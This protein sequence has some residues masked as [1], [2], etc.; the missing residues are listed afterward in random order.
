MHD[1]RGILLSLAWT[2]VPVLTL[3]AIVS[4]STTRTLSEGELRLASNK[5]EIVGDDSVN[6]SEIAQY[7]KQAPNKYFFLG[8]NPFL[9]LYNWQ[10]GSDKGLAPAIRKVGQA[11]VV[12]NRS[13]AESS[14]ENIADHLES[15]G[16]Y[17]STVDPEVD[18]KNKLAHVRYVVRPGKRY[19]I[20]SLEFV[21]P[22]NPEFAAEFENDLP[23][24]LVKKG[25]YINETELEAETARGAQYFRQLGYYD[26]SKN[27]YFFEADTLGDRNILSYQIREYTR[28]EPESNASPVRKYRFG[29][30]TIAHSPDISFRK[31]LLRELNIIN[32]G[33]L[34]SESLV[35]NA[36]NRFSSLKLFNGVSIEMSPVDSA[37]TVDCNI[38]LTQS[39]QQGLKA[40]IEA[41]T[42]SSGLLGVSPQLSLYHKNIFHGGEWLTLGFTG[43]FQFMPQ[44]S[45]H[46]TE[47]GATAS[48]SLPRIPGLP[49]SRIKGPNIPRTEFKASYNYQNRPEYTRNMAGISVGF[50][51]QLGGSTFYQI[52]PLQA[53]FIRLYN[54]DEYFEETLEHNPYL[55]DSYKNHLDAGLGGMLYHTTN[56]DI[57]PRTSYNYQRLSFDLSGNAL[58]IFSNVMNLDSDGQAKFLGVPFTQ[59]VRGQIDL[60]QTFRWGPDNGQ[61]LALHI[62]GGI[63]FAYGNSTAMP[64]EKQF[65]VGGASSMRGWQARALGPG[66][67][68]MD[69]SFSIPS[70]TGDVKFEFDLEYRFK[71]FWKL[72]GALFG[73]A[74]NVWNLNNIPDN[75]IQ[76]V[77]ADW[78]F[79]ARVDLDFILLRIDAGFKVYDPA[80]EEGSRLLTPDQWFDRNGFALHFGVGYPF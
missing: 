9:N 64:F 41:S 14:C 28:N 61:A 75:F 66:F 5:V 16:Y 59:Y 76:S 63:G 21:L 13:L 8:W 65:Y 54:L 22:D 11:P 57:V 32:P 35:T 20:D 34:Y 27:N 48:L 6:P 2:S 62:V 50:T 67:S 40:D 30:V 79:G 56:A 23:N 10:N 45:I 55:R 71:M 24:S 12:F 19:Q 33:D 53:T 1:L 77:A 68:E 46:S 80:R 60:G 31:D 7:I 18:I 15:I 4:C 25:G 72:E 36:Y 49:Y 29:N 26:F 3:A 37:S 51:G 43:N 47:F 52:Y 58:S 69:R 38:R 39:Q 78:G 17:G 74:G 42:N 44:T 70:Q 73:E